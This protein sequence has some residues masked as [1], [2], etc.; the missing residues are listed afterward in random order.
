MDNDLAS[1]LDDDVASYMDDDV[2]SYVDD[3][4]ASNVN[5]D[6]A[7]VL[8]QHKHSNPP[9]PGLD[10]IPAHKAHFTIVFQHKIS[11][12]MHLQPFI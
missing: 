7:T 3:D 6:V 12:I 8:A 1:Y 4:V 5:D 9:H 10:S 11:K 2:A